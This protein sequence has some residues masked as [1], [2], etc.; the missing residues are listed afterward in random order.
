MINREALVRRHN[1]ELSCI[2]TESPLT[3]GNGEFAFTADITGFQT[4]YDDYT[5]FPLCTMSQWGWHTTPSDKHY[6]LDDVEMTR[7]NIGGYHNAGGRE[8][9]YASLP[10]PGNE[11]VYN[12]LRHNPHRLNLGRISLMWDGVII[13]ADNIVSPKQTLDLYTGVLTSEFILFGE[14]ISVTTVCAASADVLGFSILASSS[15]LE[16]LSVGLFFPYGSHLKNASDWSSDDLHTSDIK[17][18]RSGCE[19]NEFKHGEFLIKRRLDD[20]T[21]SVMLC[22]VDSIERTRAHCFEVKGNEFTVSFSC[23]E[24]KKMSFKQVVDDSSEWWHEFWNKGGAVDFSAAKDPRAHELERRVILSQYLTAIQ[25]SGSLPPQETG[26]SCNSWYGK[27]HLEM[28]LLHAGW[29]PLWGHSTLLEKSLPWYK[30]ILDRTIENAAR[31]NY[32]GARWPKMTAPEG[33]DSPSWIATLLIW[34]Q[35]HIL[36]ML[37]LIRIS[38]P[39]DEALSFVDEYY[40]IVSETAKFMRD[41]L[42]LNEKIGFFELPPPLIPAQEEHKPE[43]VLDPVFELAYWKFGLELASKWDS[44][45]GVADSLGVSNGLGV[46]YDAVK[47]SDISPLPVIDGL[48]PAHKNCPDTFTKYNRDHPSMLF[49]YGFIP[50]NE[51]DEKVMSDTVDKV[52]ECWDLSTMWGWDFALIAMTLTRLGKPEAAL[53]VLLMETEK[54]SYTSSGNNFQRG[55]DDLPLYLPGNGSLLFA[56]PLMLKGYGDSAV[57]IGFPDNGMWDGIL[58]EGI[59]PFPY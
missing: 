2:D 41:F 57:A 5:V 21:Y 37:E 31:N 45:K 48:Y 7:Y 26:L 51:V 18:V 49:A 9:K 23:A 40:E 14:K 58:S 30:S 4:L 11:D 1:P 32:S 46:D 36:Y 19:R 15:C 47:S 54:N 27:F 13:S 25:C 34:Q 53:D 38:L 28:H 43:D 20:D 56:L 3:V 24:H 39:K 10:Q 59:S 44:I 6:T 50:C 52:L 17:N 22:G 29:F 8:Y 35:P 16:H 42:L 33:V 12:W 55:R